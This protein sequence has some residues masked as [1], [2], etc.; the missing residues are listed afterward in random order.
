MS[1]KMITTPKRQL[2]FIV[3]L[4]KCIGCQTC[5]V[6]CKKLWSTAPGQEFMYWRNVETTPGLGYPKNWQSKGGGYKNGMLQTDGHYPT[7]DE[8]GVP[9]KY[10]FAA[11]LFEGKKGSVKPS[12]EPRWAPNWDEDQGVGEYPNNIFQY[13]PRMCN[14]CENPACLEACPN[15][16]IYKRAEDGLNIVNLEKCKGAQEC[17]KACPYGK[18]YFNETDQKANKCIGCFP[19]IEKGVA[20]ACVAQCVGRAMHVGFIDDVESSVYK[21]ANVWKVAIPMHPEFGT[22]PNVLYIPP[23]VGP[24]MQDE[25]GNMMMTQKMPLDVLQGLFGPE[26]GGVLAVLKAERAKKIAG[27]GSKLMDTM[28]GELSDSMMISPMT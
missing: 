6:A 22:K 7:L 9:F 12:P 2:T 5:T 14:H 3:D 17:I 4:N 23:F 10:D 28:I 20:P 19:R 24:A 25:N 27:Q 13:L 11:R 15:D 21:L 26:V 8:Y 18:V 16:A 1:K